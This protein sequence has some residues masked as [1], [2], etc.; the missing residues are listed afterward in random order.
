[1]GLPGWE[2]FELVDGG[3][4]CIATLSYFLYQFSDFICH[5]L[6]MFF[7]MMAISIRVLQGQRTLPDW[8]VFRNLTMQRLWSLNWVSSAWYPIWSSWCKRYLHGL[9]WMVV[10]VDPIWNFSGNQYVVCLE[11]LQFYR[12]QDV[13]LCPVV[14]STLW[15]ELM[16]VQHPRVFWHSNS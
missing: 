14:S 9:L 1:M 13:Q 16:C 4:G 15:P 12:S 11:C 7:F 10:H 8:H 5:V 2:Y 6:Y 3:Y